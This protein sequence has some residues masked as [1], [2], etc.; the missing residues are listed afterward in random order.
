MSSRPTVEEFIAWRQARSEP[1]EGQAVVLTEAF[2]VALSNVESR[3]NLPE[4]WDHATPVDYPPEVRYA[5][6]LTA[7]R[8]YKRTSA[9]DGIGGGDDFGTVVIRARDPEVEA[10]IRPFRKVNGFY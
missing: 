10:L 2:D 4:G 5:V 1:S 6:F 7:N 8:L 9:P 3:V